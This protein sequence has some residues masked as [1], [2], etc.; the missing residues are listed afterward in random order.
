MGGDGGDGGY[1]YDDTDIEETT[2]DMLE[3]REESDVRA[4][5]YDREAD[6]FDQALKAE[7]AEQG[8]NAP[9]GDNPDTQVE[10][11][12]DGRG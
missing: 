6:R 2:D 9:G 12:S 11:P 3:D 5:D 10:R 1:D 4:Q 8:A 7:A